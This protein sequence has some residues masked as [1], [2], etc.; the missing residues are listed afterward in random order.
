MRFGASEPADKLLLRR[1]GRHSRAEGM[2]RPEEGKHQLAEGMEHFL[3]VDMA[4][5]PEAGKEHP[6]AAHLLTKPK[7]VISK[8]MTT[9]MQ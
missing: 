1:E 9:Y 8:S 7:G 5:H 4:R 6:L 2:V 3:G